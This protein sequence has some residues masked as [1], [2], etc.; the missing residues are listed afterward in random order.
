M[1]LFELVIDALLAGLL[2][3]TILYCRLL[4]KRIRVLQDA[5]SELAKLLTHFDDST[6][7]ASESIALLNLSGK[8]AADAVQAR[9]ENATVAADDLTY[10]IERATV[11]SERMEAGLHVNRTARRVQEEMSAPPPQLKPEPA[12]APVPH[13]PVMTREA[14]PDEPKANL[15]ALQAMIEKI[16][17]RASNDAGPTPAARGAAPRRAQKAPEAKA[18]SRV[19]QELLEIIRAGKV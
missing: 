10:L 4:N 17:G 18:R 1:P 14:Q 13:A 7:R 16:A 5:R 3:M 9:I 12:R 6:R 15:S 19:E 2:L 8:K 11:I